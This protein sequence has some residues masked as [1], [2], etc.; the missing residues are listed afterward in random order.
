MVKLSFFETDKIML[1]GHRGASGSTPENTLVSMERAFAEGAD[2]VETDLRESQDGEILIFHDETLDRTTNGKGEVRHRPLNELKGLD[3]GYGFSSDGGMSFPYRGQRIEIPTLEE[4]FTSFPQAKVTLDVKEGRIPF[5]HNVIA[6]IKRWNK[7]DQVLLGAENDAVMGKIRR[8]IR[9]QNTIIATGFSY[10]EAEAFMQW[11]WGG[12]KETFV[13]QGHA[14]QVP[15]VYNEMKLIQPETLDAARDL[16]VEVHA[17][18]I[19]DTHEMDQLIRMG[20]GG[21]VTDYPARLKDLMAKMGSE[22]G[23]GMT[24]SLST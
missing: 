11:V 22:G 6:C 17:W 5:I 19:N 7:A 18:T 3:A 12:R 9:D 20:V 14:L 23:K 16:G 15:R 8:Q 4:F 1:G 13:P 24:H 10:G 2:F 21:I